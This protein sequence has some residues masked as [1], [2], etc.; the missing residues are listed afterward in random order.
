M[1]ET[2]EHAGWHGWIEG[3]QA[4]PD[5]ME[6]HL[7]EAMDTRDIASTAGLSAF[8]Y[9]RIFGALCGMTLGESIRK[10]RMTLAAQELL[11]TDIRVIDLSVKYGYES[12]DSFSRAFQRFHGVT[13]SRAREPGAPLRSLAPL[14]IRMTLEGGSMLD[15]Q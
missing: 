2:R 1:T 15:D 12:P 13:P 5:S 10:R 11:R 14:H 6:A 3:M 4:S 7:T 8:C 9:Q